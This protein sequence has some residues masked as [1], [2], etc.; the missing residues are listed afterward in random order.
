MN[1]FRCLLPLALP[2]SNAS[3]SIPLVVLYILPFTRHIVSTY[4]QQTDY[5]Y[6]QHIGKSNTPH[7]EPP[8]FNM[9]APITA[10]KRHRGNKLGERRGKGDAASSRDASEEGE[11][12]HHGPSGKYAKHLL[13]PFYYTYAYFVPEQIMTRITMFQMSHHSLL[14]L[15]TLAL[16]LPLLPL[17]LPLPHPEW[18]WDKVC[19]RPYSPTL[20]LLL[21]QMQPDEH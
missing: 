3:Y 4:K 21:S 20:S 13:F 8:I 5:T 12:C 1:C 10:P 6:F 19:N 18:Q 17:P 11:S 16:V 9:A 15:P 2:P 14:R 7:L